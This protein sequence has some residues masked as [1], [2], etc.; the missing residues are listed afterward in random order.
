MNRRWLPPVLLGSFAVLWVWAAIDPTYRFDW[1]LEN[2]LVVLCLPALVWA[3]RRGMFTDASLVLL[4]LFSSM[5][6][7]GSHWTY[8]NVPWPDWQ[9]MGFERNHYDRIVHFSYGFLLVVPFAELYRRRGHGQGLVS[10]V[11]FVLASSAFYEI[12]EWGTV[13]VVDPGA[14]AAFLGTQGDEFDA[15]KDM[16]LASLGAVLTATA[17][18]LAR[19]LRRERPA[20]AT[21]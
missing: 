17:I 9:A 1:F 8:S 2:L 21:A 19:R 3:Q 20:P 11:Q 10:A 15:I 6:V 12:L 4:W 7:V 18:A 13:A 5:H 14:G 16:A